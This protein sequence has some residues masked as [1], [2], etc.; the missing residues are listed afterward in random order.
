VIEGCIRTKLAVV[1]QD[2]RDHGARASLNLG[3]TFAHAL[4]AATSFRG[5][6]HGEA[7]GL[8]LIVALRI[9][10]RERGLDPAVPDQVLELLR[11]HGLPTTFSGP[12]TDQILAHAALD[13]KRRGGRHNLVLLESPGHVVRD[14]E[15]S[16]QALRDAIEEVRAGEE[17]P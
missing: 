2:E 12:S 17:G 1:A 8:G 5:Y 11:R 15:V 4:E 14:C 7:V 6:R 16:D 9:S 13:K 3:H 10:Q